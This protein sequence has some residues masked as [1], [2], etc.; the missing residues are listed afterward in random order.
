MEN[1]ANKALEAMDQLN[2]DPNTELDVYVDEATF[3]I[4]LS[5]FFAKRLQ[6]LG[7]WILKQQKHE[8]VIKCYEHLAQDGEQVPEEM[9]CFNIQT[10][11]MLMQA[12][13]KA[14]VEQGGTKKMKVYEIRESIENAS[15]ISS[16]LNTGLNSHT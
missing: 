4:K 3:N 11:L 13:D 12:I 6:A 9:Y 16:D 2:M 8:D 10:Y 5:G 1:T 15:K 7:E 14:A